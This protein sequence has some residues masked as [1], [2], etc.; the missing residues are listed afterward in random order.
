M[1]SLTICQSPL[2]LLLQ[3]LTKAM[4]VAVLFSQGV[5]CITQDAIQDAE[6]ARFVGIAARVRQRYIDLLQPMAFDSPR[7]IRWHGAGAG[8]LMLF[9]YKGKKHA[10]VCTYQNIPFTS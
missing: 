8:I 2:S 10:C 3:G 1:Y 6:Y 7:D 4:L 5:P 9:V